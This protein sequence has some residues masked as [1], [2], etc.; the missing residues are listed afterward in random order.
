MT[1]VKKACYTDAIME[2][3]KKTNP[4]AI[5]VFGAPGSGKTVF[6][7]NFSKRFKAPYYNLDDLRDQFNF[8][9]AQITVL[10]KSILKTKQNI[11][12]EGGLDTEASR[13][14]LY[15]VCKASNYDSS[16][17]WIQTDV[18][19]IKSR[20]KMRLKSASKAKED[21]ES[22]IREMEAPSDSEKPIILSGKHT[23]ESQLSQVLSQLA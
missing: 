12:I 8:S 7:K 4:R 1:T 15:R 6:C 10:L 21:Y 23:F 11:I 14:A 19:T 16:L 22:R 13:K 3:K 17:I 20:L 2:G 5:L 18:N 9:Q